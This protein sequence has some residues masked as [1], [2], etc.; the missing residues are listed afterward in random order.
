MLGYLL[1][2]FVTPANEQDRAQVEQ[3]TREVQEVTGEAVELAFGDQGY[4]GAQP[5]EDAAKHGIQLEVVKLPEARN[6]FALLLW[7]WVVARSF[8]WVATPGSQL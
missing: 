4:T 1:T 8:A 3:L 2:L 6:G 5:T 7:H